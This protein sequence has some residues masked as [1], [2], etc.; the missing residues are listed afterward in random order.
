MRLVGMGACVAHR[1]RVAII[2]N[3]YPQTSETFIAQE[4]L[5]LQKAGLAFIIVSLEKPR[6]LRRNSLNAEIKAE[7]HYI[8]H[9]IFALPSVC[10]AWRRVRRLQGYRTALRLFF[11]DLLRSGNP[12]MLNQ[13][14]RALIACDRFRD[15]AI[16]FHAHFVNRPAAVARYAASMISVAWSCSAHAK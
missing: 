5:G 2:L 6:N 9:P 11:G 12:L 4:L 3:C 15:D 1:G 16:H 13:F 14:A 8:P 7:V 10:R